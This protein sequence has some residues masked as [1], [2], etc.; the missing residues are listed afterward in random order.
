YDV[1]GFRPSWVLKVTVHGGE[2]HH[3]RQIEYS[4]DVETAGGYTALSYPMASAVVLFKEAGLETSPPPPGRDYTLL[5]RQRIA[6]QLLRLYC[7]AIR[8]KGHPDR[9]EYVWLDEFCLSD[10]HLDSEDQ[11]SQQRSIELG[12][13]ADIF[14]N[15]NQVT[16][17]CHEHDCDHTGLDCI[18]G[19]RLWTIPEILHAQNVSRLTRRRVGHQTITSLF[20]TTAR[21]FRE[22]LQ[23]KAALGNRWHL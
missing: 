3:F 5:D 23:M 17:F 1:T 19:T 12:R 14:R 15:A 13:L 4:Q 11:I 2:L 22:A 8:Q 16:V 18:W 10:F 9:T 6:E 7:S 20:P 21:A